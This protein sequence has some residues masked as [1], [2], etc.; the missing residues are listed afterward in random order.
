MLKHCCLI[1]IKMTRKSV[2]S[3]CFTMKELQL[4]VFSSTYITVLTKSP[5]M[6]LINVFVLKKLY[7]VFCFLQRVIYKQRHV[8]FNLI[9]SERDFD[10]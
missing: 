10:V 3:L 9:F 5:W 4:F 2:E 7:T 1:Y 8:L 6:F